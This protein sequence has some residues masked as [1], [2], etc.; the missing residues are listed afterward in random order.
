MRE[1]SIENRCLIKT[2]Q[3]LS[4]FQEVRMGD[5]DSD[6]A[7]TDS[8]MHKIDELDISVFNATTLISQTLEPTVIQEPIVSPPR[9][10]LRSRDE[11]GPST[12]T[13]S[14]ISSISFFLFLI[15]V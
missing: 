13:R 15:Y 5:Q 11:G 12:R 4:G 8:I 1:R 10:R 2:L 3:M 6:A 9:T 7:H 14:A